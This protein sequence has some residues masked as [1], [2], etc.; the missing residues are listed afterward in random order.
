M[1]E[2]WSKCLPYVFMAVAAL[3]RWPNL[4]PP[5]FSAGAPI[6]TINSGFADLFTPLSRGRVNINTASPDVLQLIPGV[7]AI[8]AEAIAAAR[9]G[10]DDGSGLTGPYRS[11]DQVRRVPEVNLE[12][13][14]LLAQYCDVRSRT[15]QVQI[16]AHVGA[17]KRQFIAVLGRNNPRDIQVLSFY[18][19]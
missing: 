13:A 11:V 1:S 17:A 15:F 3:S 10:E 16:D 12:V 18:W 4:F 7:N 8:V 14:R 9:Q 6:S 19:K 5:N 2:K